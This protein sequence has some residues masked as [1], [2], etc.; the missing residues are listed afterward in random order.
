MV[1]IER[2]WTLAGV[3]RQQIPLQ[4]VDVTLS[5]STASTR[6]KLRTH[7]ANRAGMFDCH[8]DCW[9]I[10]PSRAVTIGFFSTCLL[11]EAS[12]Q[13]GSHLV[14]GPTPAKLVTLSFGPLTNPTTL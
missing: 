14:N 8:S 9:L 12:H 1:W 10:K 4:T 13:Q 2:V 6:S 11:L 5:Q 7:L 3:G